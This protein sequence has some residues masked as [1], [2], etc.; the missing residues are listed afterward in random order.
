M[1]VR[2]ISRKALHNYIKTNPISGP[3]LLAWASIVESQHWKQPLDIVQTFGSKAV[4]I[5]GKKDNKI[6]TVPPER[7][8]ID[9][10]GNHLRVILKY[11]F[12]PNLTIPCMY[13]KW[14]GTH[15]TYDKLCAKNEQYDVE[16]F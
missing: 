13:I 3:A 2:I 1:P 8:V 16:Q 10:K 9:V 14:I 12:N 15:A 6:G 11:Q 4:D 5:L 7:V